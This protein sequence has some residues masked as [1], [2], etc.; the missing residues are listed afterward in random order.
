MKTNALHQVIIDESDMVD[1]FYRADDVG[2]IVVDDPQWAERLN[3]SLSDYGITTLKWEEES[4]LS[5][6]QFIEAN[7]ANW[8]LPESYATLDLEN[9]LLS[10]CETDAQRERVNMELAEYT[11]RDLLVVLRWMKYFVDT[12][13]EN[14]LV[15]GVGRGSSVASYVLYLLDVHRVDSLAYDLDIK[16]FLK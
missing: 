13:R 15:W 16:E 3:R 5:V 7:R 4:D 11:N 2:T 14:R 9:Y 12:M 10:K 8:H 1:V 6:D